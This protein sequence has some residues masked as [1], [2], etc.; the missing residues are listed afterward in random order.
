MAQPAAADRA[1]RAYQ[2]KQQAAKRQW[3]LAVLASGEN[4][5]TVRNLAIAVGL[6]VAARLAAGLKVTPS[7]LSRQPQ[8]KKLAAAVTATAAARSL[9]A[10]QLLPGLIAQTRADAAAY[11]AARG[12]K[13]DGFS[14]SSDEEHAAVDVAVASA[15]VYLHERRKTH[16]KLRT[17]LAGLIVEEANRPIKPFTTAS[18]I[19]AAAG[20]VLAETAHTLTVLATETANAGRA[21]I[22]A[23]LGRAGFWQWVTAND[24]RTCPDC[25][26]RHGRIYPTW[27]SFAEF[28][29]RCRCIAMPL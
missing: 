16:A 23:A 28:H 26:A 22:F 14:R 21:V 25:E 17:K 1:T 4:D 11:T 2:R 9:L 27:T 19:A 29:P 10:E 6:I 5:H 24:D 7:W 18:V 3:T 20:R 8:F 12:R 13:L 15:V